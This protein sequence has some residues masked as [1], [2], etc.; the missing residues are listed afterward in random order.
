MLKK[1]ITITFVMVT[2][3]SVFSLSS[4]AEKLTGKENSKAKPL[5]Y[6]E[7]DPEI[8]TRMDGVVDVLFDSRYYAYGDQL[9]KVELFSYQHEIYVPLQGIV[10]AR[11]QSLNWDEAAQT[12]TITN[13]NTVITP[14]LEEIAERWAYPI[15]GRGGYRADHVRLLEFDETIGNLECVGRAETYSFQLTEQEREQYQ[16][17]L[18]EGLASGDYY[19][20]VAYYPWPLATGPLPPEE[21]APVFIELSRSYSEKRQA[22]VR[23]I[24]IKTEDEWGPVVLSTEALEYEGLL[25]VSITALGYYNTAG[26]I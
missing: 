5:D 19:R 14:Q 3:L 24:I 2:I 25:Y 11:Y 8:L 4:C 26:Q 20:L 13:Y 22:I 6:T 7:A 16:D 9:L 10:E 23:P 17:L 15:Q 21:L 1:V 18:A 12:A